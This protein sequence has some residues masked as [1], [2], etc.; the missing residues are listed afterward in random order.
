MKFV[1]SIKIVIPYDWNKFVNHVKSLIIIIS[2]MGV[3]GGD[4]HKYVINQHFDNLSLSN[5]R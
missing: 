3:F 4:H 5:G 2:Q 1:L